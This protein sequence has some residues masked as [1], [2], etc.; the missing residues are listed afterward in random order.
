M[1]FLL[2]EKRSLYRSPDNDDKTVRNYI[3]DL[4]EEKPAKK[5][6]SCG[7]RDNFNSS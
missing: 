7:C 1:F 3:D 2:T 5:S 6:G 4:N